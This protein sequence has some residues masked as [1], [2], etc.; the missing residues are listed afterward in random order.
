M[1]NIINEKAVGF[2]PGTPKIT[3]NWDSD[4]R[5]YH[6]YENIKVNAADLVSNTAVKNKDENAGIINPNETS[7]MSE[8][9]LNNAVYNT[10]VNGIQ[11]TPEIDFSDRGL[12]RLSNVV[13]PNNNKVYVNSKEVPVFVEN[14][15]INSNIFL[16]QDVTLVDVLWNSTKVKPNNNNNTSTAFYFMCSHFM[17]PPNFKKMV[18]EKGELFDIGHFLDMYDK[19]YYTSVYVLFT[20]QGKNTHHFVLQFIFSETMSSLTGSI[21]LYNISDYK[22]NK[23][24]K[25]NKFWLAEWNALSDGNGIICKPTDSIIDKFEYLFLTKNSSKK[26]VITRAVAGYM[27][28]LEEMSFRG[29]ESTINNKIFYSC[30]IQVIDKTLT[31][32]PPPIGNI[33]WSEGEKYNLPNEEVTADSELREQKDELQ[34]CSITID[35]IVNRGHPAIFQLFKVKYP[36]GFVTEGPIHTDVGKKPYY[37]SLPSSKNVNIPSN[38]ITLDFIDQQKKDS[39][40]F[41]VEF[42]EFNYKEYLPLFRNAVFGYDPDEIKPEKPSWWVD[43]IYPTSINGT[44]KMDGISFNLGF[45]IPPDTTDNDLIKTREFLQKLKGVYPVTLKIEVVDGESDIDK[46]IVFKGFIT[47]GISRRRD[48]QKGELYITFSD[49]SYMLKHQIVMGLPFYDG[50]GHVSALK[51][52]LARAGY[53]RDTPTSKQ[54]GFQLSIPMDRKPEFD[55]KMGTS[56]YNCI[57]RIVE[58]VGEWFIVERNGTFSLKTPKDVYISLT[59]FMDKLG[60]TI[61]GEETQF[62]FKPQII[63]GMNVCMFFE[64]ILSRNMGWFN[65]ILSPLEYSEGFDSSYN[66]YAVF[67][68]LPAY[69]RKKGKL[70]ISS[71]SA[72]LAKKIPAT[73]STLIERIK[74]MDKNVENGLEYVYFPFAKNALFSEPDLNTIEAVE[75]KAKKEAKRLFMPQTSVSFT[76]F[77]N[78]YCK[79]FSIAVIVETSEPKIIVDR[80]EKS[81][82]LGI[83]VFL[84][85]EVNHTIDV[86][87]KTWFV[88]LKGLRIYEDEDFYPSPSDFT[89]INR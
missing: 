6:R 79:P 50:W 66:L 55:F 86:N 81:Y 32:Q 63:S 39:L 54:D 69:T 88:T 58:Y 85:E 9:H 57:K 23:A 25:M 46:E 8:F 47:S 7:N 64:E 51:D 20:V 61:S 48:A 37:I 72:Y 42:K 56:F 2:R 21:K 18:E 83:G 75:T 71:Y 59:D 67:G 12:L 73:W 22:L 36:E 68:L 13:E 4:Y 27:L 52:L 87:N 19:G 53:L 16:D 40:E 35:A 26:G 24:I 78:Y 30:I 33:V 28:K 3:L 44:E 11:P 84:I 45:Y 41:K 5:W 31:L 29:E 62:S 70:E 1:A 49:R 77:G 76:T 14:T 60:K 10:L 43:N 38:H 74:N 82:G 80:G 34:K 17:P 15:S 65:I 89:P